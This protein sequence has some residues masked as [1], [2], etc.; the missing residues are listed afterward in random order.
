LSS[1]WFPVLR[2]THRA[3]IARRFSWVSPRRA[4][5][6]IATGIERLVFFVSLA[7]VWLAPAIVR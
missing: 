5:L 7:I 3:S 6:L 4:R 1:A 2:G